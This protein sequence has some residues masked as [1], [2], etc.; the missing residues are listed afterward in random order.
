MS[1]P[2]LA[3]SSPGP[4]CKQ[5]GPPTKLCDVDFHF[6]WFHKRPILERIDGHWPGF[7][8]HFALLPCSCFCFSCIHWPPAPYSLLVRINPPCLRLLNSMFHLQDKRH[9]FPIREAE[10]IRHQASGV[11]VAQKQLAARVQSGPR[12]K[13]S[14]VRLDFYR[15]LFSA[16][17]VGRHSGCGGAECPF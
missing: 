3:C 13:S 16:A 15:L 17:F 10:D 1:R 9:L 2:S 4:A 14:F 12:R 5:T 6:C 7:V 8:S 11:P